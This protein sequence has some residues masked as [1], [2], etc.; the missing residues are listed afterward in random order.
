[1]NDLGET[2]PKLHRCARENQKPLN[3]AQSKHP[4]A[5]VTV[6]AVKTPACPNH[7]QNARTLTRAG[8]GAVHNIKA[9][10]A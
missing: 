3:P 4:L 7:I 5:S 9:E 8:G 1:M 2:I 6:L 10:E